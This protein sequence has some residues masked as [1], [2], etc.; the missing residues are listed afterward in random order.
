M[1]NCLKDLF[2]YD[3]GKKCSKCRNNLLKSNFHKKLGS[4]DGLDP[5]CVPCLKNNYLDNRDRV[6]RYYLN[7]QD[8]LNNYQKNYNYGN[9][10][11]INFYIKNKRITDVNFRLIRNT[12]RRIHHALNGNSKSSSTL[13]ILGI[14]IEIDHVKA[15][16]MFD[17]SKDEKLK[18]AFNWKNTQVLLKADHKQKGVEFNCLN[19]QLQ[20]IK[21]YQFIK[22]NSQEGLN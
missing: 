10:E 17:V 15:I 9:K 19:Y 3:S 18:E 6:K 2:D 13:D 14:D 7:N 22:L 1:S 20:L 4:K 8:R 5:R 12:R 21:A 16:C 11:K